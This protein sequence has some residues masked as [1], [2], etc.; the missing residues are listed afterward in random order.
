MV[1][2]VRGA[3]TVANNNA[4]E[5]L[6]ETQRLLCEMAQRNELKEDD[7]ISIIFTLTK[8]LDAV[9]PAIAARN[10]GWTSTALMC[11]NEIDVPG[12]LEKCIRIMMHV[13]TD[14]D[15]KDIKHVYLNGAK[16][17]RPDLT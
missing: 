12:S 11:M 8:D 6:S 15:K 17:L 5:I 4:D 2:A 7:I 16:V 10:I 14:K 9:F 3:T 13:N 1:R